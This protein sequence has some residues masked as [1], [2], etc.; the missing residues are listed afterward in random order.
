MRTFN[1]KLILWL[2]GI[3][4]VTAVAVHI[5]HKIQV[6]RN[7]GA[8]L[9]L[10]TTQEA[11]ARDEKLGV[12]ERMKALELARNNYRRYLSLE[13]TDFE[14]RAKYGKL[15]LVQASREDLPRAYFQFERVLR[16]IPATVEDATQQAANEKLDKEIRTLHVDLAGALGRYP[17]AIAHLD[18][19]KA[20]AKEKGEKPEVLFGL[21]ERQADLKLAA[22]DPEGARKILEDILNK[23]K[24]GDPGRVPAARR[25]IDILW[26]RE[27]DPTVARE[28]ADAMLAANPNDPDALLAHAVFQL[29][30]NKADASKPN[31]TQRELSDERVKMARK[32]CAEAL[33][34]RPN[35]ADGLALAAQAALRDEVEDAK[36]RRQPDFA[37]AHDLLRKSLT[38]HPNAFSRWILLARIEL[39]MRSGSGDEQAAFTAALAVIEEGVAAVEDPRGKLELSYFWAETLIGKESVLQRLSPPVELSTTET[40]KLNGLLTEMDKLLP[41]R[42]AVAFLYA[43]RR[44]AQQQWQG[45]RIDLEKVRKSISDQQ[46]GDKQGADAAAARLLPRINSLL[47]QCYQRL[48][49]DDQKVA[50]YK[51]IMEEDSSDPAAVR[52]YAD[53]LI[54]VGRFEEGL[55]EYERW[56]AMVPGMNAEQLQRY[57]FLR[58]IAAQRLPL[59]NGE[60]EAALGAL[61]DMFNSYMGQEKVAAEFKNEP[62]PVLMQVELAIALDRAKQT[63]ESPTQTDKP[64]VSPQVANGIKEILSTVRGTEG[65]KENL[66]IWVASV[67]FAQ[68]LKDPEADTIWQELEKHFGDTFDVRMAKA[69]YLIASKGEAAVPEL[70]ALTENLPADVKDSQRA[71]M[72]GLFGRLCASVGKTDE[73]LKYLLRTAELAPGQLPVRMQALLFAQQSKNVE[74]ANKLAAEIDQLS[75]GSDD[76]HY[77]RAVTFLTQYMVS[78]QGKNEPTEQ[79]LAYLASAETELVAAKEVRK[80]WALPYVVLGMIEHE[81]KHFDAAADYYKEAIDRGARDPG[82][83]VA[84]V[85]KLTRLGRLAEADQVIQKLEEQGAAETSEV[86]VIASKVATE[87]E[88]YD[89]AIERR[90]TAISGGMTD[91]QQYLALA[92]LYRVQGEWDKAI[93]NV[94][95]A[96]QADTRLG[97]PATADGQTENA[98]KTE[99]PGER[100]GLPYVVKVQMLMA[101]SQQMADPKAGNDLKELAKATAAVAAGKDEQGQ[102]N[103]APATRVQ[104]IAQIQDLLG[105]RE[106]AAKMFDEAVQAAPDDVTLQ[107]AAARFYARQPVPELRESAK[108]ILTRFLNGELKRSASA[109]VDLLIWARREMASILADS[110]TYEDFQ[111]AV[112]LSHENTNVLNSD[113]F[114]SDPARDLDRL[115]EMENEARLLAAR[116]QR[117]ALKEAVSLLEQRAKQEPPPGLDV[118]FLRAQLYLALGRWPEANKLMADVVASAQKSAD[119]TVDRSTEAHANLARYI[120]AYITALLAHGEVNDAQG[121]IAVWRRSDPGSFGAT[122]AEARSLVPRPQSKVP[123]KEEDAKKKGQNEAKPPEMKVAEALQ[124]LETSVTDRDLSPEEKNRRMLLSVMVME[125]LFKIVLEYGTPAEADLM[126]ARIR[127]YYQQIIDSEPD[128]AAQRQLMRVRFLVLAGERPQAVELL[129]QY[130]QSTP[131]ETLVIACQT[132]LEFNGELK[133]LEQAAAAGTMPAEEAERRKKE[134]L[135]SVGEAELITQQALVKSQQALAGAPDSLPMEKFQ[136]ANEVATLLSLLGGHYLATK[137][138]NDAMQA[139]TQVLALA[140]NNIIALNNLAMI[141][142]GTKSKLPEALGQVESAIRLIGPIPLIV[143]SKA[144]VLHASGKYPEALEAA[145]QVIAEEPDDLDKQSGSDLAKSWGGYHFH[146]ALMYDATNGTVNAAKEFKRA[147][148]LGFGE[149]DVSDLEVALWKEMAGK[150]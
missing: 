55:A 121:W 51:S 98:T 84:V 109:E 115:A 113:E 56:H 108:K 81:R 21:S 5:T 88:D 19:L 119:R 6:R 29:N 112:E 104:T 76:A 53:A 124:V 77:A 139:Y 41:G 129:K 42:P 67:E 66:A 38:L 149:A 68:Q 48:G 36:G 150:Y 125:D 126:K 74:A 30:D 27:Q 127:D 130:W 96:I 85:N 34:T 138:Y 82:I 2:A 14:A 37:A 103:V 50:A 140:P 18:V 106:D 105:N 89:R 23:E 116:D 91:A 136:R 46:A 10:A 148:E 122:L 133:K 59:R 17:D 79:D 52:N 39:G 107:E 134:L 69:R 72:Y 70:A 12:P 83:V 137:R 4:L 128:K 33:A 64:T 47:A 1:L 9:E 111:K 86:A 117:T 20:K 22:N 24:G 49:N 71:Q 132:L 100:T 54:S 142:A 131:I 15:L 143:D 93:E 120:N 75:P 16:D 80:S 61:R 145:Q 8:Y 95:R 97:T 25:L 13:P 32:E 141:M 44:V 11:V 87:L 114:K 65:M 7:A 118:E 102:D 45:A 123:A 147:R 57:T 26:Q 43:Y 144:M 92:Y 110:G 3:F 94:D 90:W 62:W 101:R 31:K 146:L 35:D 73:A 60:R 63:L 78:M 28:T 99:K 40:E 135:T 58:F